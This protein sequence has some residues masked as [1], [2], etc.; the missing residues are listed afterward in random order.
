MTNYSPF[1][2]GE[3]RL[4][5]D[6]QPGV[7]AQEVE[8]LLFADAATAEQKT[9]PAASWGAA[10]PA[11]PESLT[12]APDASDV[13][14]LGP[15][16]AA[17]L[18][19]GVEVFGEQG[20]AARQPARAHAHSPSPRTA[21]AVGA[22]V[23]GASRI[24]RVCATPRATTLANVLPVTFLVFGSAASVWIW[25]LQLNPVLA[26]ITGAA[27]LVGTLFARLLLRG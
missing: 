21:P 17:T 2:Y 15:G 16:L 20:D 4:D 9:P 5:A 23:L 8:D 25:K 3:V 24:D 18:D 19:V 27:T 1:S 22:A 10:E 26:V 13:G 14:G 6:P 7:T 11:S 12:P